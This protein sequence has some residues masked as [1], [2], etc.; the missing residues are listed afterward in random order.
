MVIKCS[1]RETPEKQIVKTDQNGNEESKGEMEIML[2][3]NELYKFIEIKPI[4]SIFREQVSI[5]ILLA[6]IA[7]IHCWNSFLKY[8]SDRGLPHWIVLWYVSSICS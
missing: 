8:I 2:P 4:T 6:F 1:N 5:T 3:D 7:C